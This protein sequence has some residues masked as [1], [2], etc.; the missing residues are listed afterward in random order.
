MEEKRSPH[1]QEKI[2]ELVKEEVGKII[3]KDIDIDP[4][5]LLTITHVKVS[6]DLAHATIFISTLAPE[7][8]EGALS[9]LRANIRD[10][11]HTLNR[12]FRTRPVPK[13]VFSVDTAYEREHRLHDILSHLS[14]TNE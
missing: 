10:I 8:E 4:N 3:I 7:Q 1:R 2:A 13:I 14:D 11:Q 6:P 5:I 12:K 9:V